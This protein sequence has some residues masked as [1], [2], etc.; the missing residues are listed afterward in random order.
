MV[1]WRIRAHLPDRGHDAG[2]EG[3]DVVDDGLAGLNTGVVSGHGDETSQS[4]HD[5]DEEWCSLDLKK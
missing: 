5:D 3:V 1:F 4:R 2:G